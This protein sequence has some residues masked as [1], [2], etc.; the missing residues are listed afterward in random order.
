MTPEELELIV[1]QNDEP[2]T[3]PFFDEPIFVDD[4]RWTEIQNIQELNEQEIL[5]YPR[6]RR[7][8]D[9]V[10]DFG[11][12]ILAYYVPAIFHHP[13]RP[14][15]IYLRKTGIDTIRRELLRM[16]ATNGMNFEHR[17]EIFLPLAIRKLLYH[18]LSHF[19]IEMACHRHDFLTRPDAEPILLTY[20]N[21]HER[22]NHDNEEAI[23]N[24]NVAQ[25]MSD[26][27][28][29]VEL[30]DLNVQLLRRDDP[31]TLLLPCKNYIRDFMD[32]QPNGYRRYTRFLHQHPRDLLF[33]LELAPVSDETIHEFVEMRKLNALFNPCPVFIDNPL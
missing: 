26:A 3:A 9:F 2:I 22:L 10:R 11:I 33:H 4:R 27:N 29:R 28:I 6:E 14:W 31:A 17:P 13:D 1:Q 24:V 7:P 21:F 16:S 23:C 5:Q 20:R 32:S 8:L 19:A 18:E 15:G 25:K 30:A 12:D